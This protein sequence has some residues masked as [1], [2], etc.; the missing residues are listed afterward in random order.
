MTTKKKNAGTARGTQKHL[1]DD[2]NK[3]FDA[4]SR[5]P[6]M[7]PEEEI[8]VAELWCSTR[9]PAHADRLARANLRFVVKVAMEY[10]NYGFP[11]LDLIQEGN[12]GLMRSL[13]T[14]DP[15]R[16]FRLI[17][18][19]VWWIRAFIQEY[20]LKNW[21]LVKIGT[22]QRERKMFNKLISARNRTRRVTDDME[23]QQRLQG[24]ADATG[25]TLEEARDLERRIRSVPTWLDSV[26]RSD[27]DRGQPLH[28]KF[29]SDREDTEE[30][31][32]RKEA[33]SIQNTH[34]REAMNQ[35]PE[36]D[37]LIVEARHLEDDKRTLRE[38]GATLGVSKER[39]RQLEVKALS[40][41]QQLISASCDVGELL[42]A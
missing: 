7:T 29:A 21:S 18:Y 5:A 14:F 38:L 40:R 34:L 33:T 6:L 35:L 2:L 37:R 31:V 36:R 1:S 20:I 26:T 41:L 9:D 23:A 12:L 3:Y 30:L 22:T 42:A 4:L 8:E 28:E 16:K 24:I 32:A 17:S 27:D 19:A 11:L 13:Q 15:T 39:V 10:R 25:A